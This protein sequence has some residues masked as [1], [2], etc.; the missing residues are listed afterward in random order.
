MS[1]CYSSIG[2]AALL[3]GTVRELFEEIKYRWNFPPRELVLS[4]KS[5]FAARGMG[6]SSSLVQ[7]VARAYLDSGEKVLD[8]FAETVITNHDALGLMSDTEV[9]RVIA[10]AHQE[11]FDELC[12]LILGE[13][14]GLGE[15]FR[16]LAMAEIAER[17]N[18]VWQHLHRKILLR[19]LAEPKERDQKFGILLSSNQAERD[20]DAWAEKVGHIA[21]LFVDLDRFKDLNEGYTEVKIDQTILPDVQRLLANLVQCRGEAYRYGGDEFLLIVPNVDVREAE[22]FAER[23]REEFSRPRFKVNNEVV[24]V[25]VSIGVAVWPRNGRTYVEVLGAANTAKAEAK[26]QRGN[27]VKLAPVAEKGEAPETR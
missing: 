22:A 17:Q 1:F 8:E 27:T 18:R 12:A 13:P 6:Q 24:V 14:R 10:D 21:V 4:I 19:K 5:E 16:A 11:L 9:R 7:A 15:G 2:G 20:F 3:E 26:K 23:V 25:T